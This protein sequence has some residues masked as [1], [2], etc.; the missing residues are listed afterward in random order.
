[1]IAPFQPEGVHAAD[2][3]ERAAHSWVAALRQYTPF[4]RLGTRAARKMRPLTTAE[5]R[6]LRA[7][8]ER[9]IAVVYRVF[10]EL[11]EAPRDITPSN[12]VPVSTVEEV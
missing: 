9:L 4:C 3:L 7:Q 5:E 2:S 6:I 11:S 10:A 8:G 1:V 12:G